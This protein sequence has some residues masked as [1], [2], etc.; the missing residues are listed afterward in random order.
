MAKL[1]LSLPWGRAITKQVLV[2]TPK[3]IQ[4]QTDAQFNGNGFKYAAAV[5]EKDR[6]ATALLARADG[7]LKHLPNDSFWKDVRVAALKALKAA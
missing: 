4:Y 7:A 1:L 3:G 5:L 6:N 2:K